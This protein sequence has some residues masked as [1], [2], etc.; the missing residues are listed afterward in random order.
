MKILLI[1]T[2][3][4][5]GGAE[6]SLTR[7]ALNK[8]AKVDYQLSSF[9]IEGPWSKWV[10]TKGH[11]PIIFGE[12]ND[13]LSGTLL[14]ASINLYK[15][16]RSNDYSAIYVCGTKVSLCVKIIKILLPKIKII[17]AIRWNPNQN[18]LLDIFF[19]FTEKLTKFLVAHWI[20]N[21]LTQKN[22]LIK[23]CK[24]NPDNISVIHNGINIPNIVFQ[25][26]QNKPIKI[27][28]VANITKRKGYLEYLSIIKNLSKKHKNLFFTFIG[29]DESSGTL[30]NRIKELGLSDIVSY[31]GYIKNVEDFYN[32]SDIFV[33]PSLYGEGCPT[34]ILEAFSYNLPVIAYNID[35]NHELVD[36]LEDGLLLKLGQ[37]NEFEEAIE[38]LAANSS[39]RTQMGSKGYT[40]IKNSFTL[41]NCTFKHDEKIRKIVTGA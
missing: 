40:K 11:K 36:N 41:D 9:G 17:H 28:T 27:L 21:S 37:N 16:L 15:L 12:R 18:N 7:M 4:N 30:Q 14:G 35:G 3:S 8:K 20:T 34:V 38:K 19:I 26:K 32:D 24:I 22:T 5:I 2:S 29:R 6:A 23:R 33:L 10:R 31:Q 1:F 25:K 39:F 13:V